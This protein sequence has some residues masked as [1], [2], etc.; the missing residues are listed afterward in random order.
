METQKTPNSQNN[1]EKKK[2]KYS[3]RSQAP[4]HETVLQ[5]YTNGDGKV[6]EQKK[7]Y[8]SMEQKR[9]SRDKPM[10]LIY[11]KGARLYKGEKTVSSIRVQG[12]LDNYM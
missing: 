4:W 10:H 5:I 12:K 3:W 8:K 2:K 6:L 1:L 7:K 11:D 9:K